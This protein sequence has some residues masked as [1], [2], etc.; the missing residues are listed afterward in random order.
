LFLF[1]LFNKDPLNNRE[2]LDLEDCWQ[3]LAAMFE[4]D[5]ALNY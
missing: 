2:W 1:F 3:A 4:L 5:A